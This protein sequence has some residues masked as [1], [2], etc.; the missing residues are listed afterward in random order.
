[1]NQVVSD[2]EGVEGHQD[3]LIVH[4]SDKVVHGQ[5]PIDLLRRLI[6]KNITVNLNKCSF[7]VLSSKSFGYLVDGNGLKADTKQLAPLTNAPFPKHLTELRSLMGAL[8]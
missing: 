1:M 8:Q 2:L 7:C 4:G 3:D 6:E 5:R